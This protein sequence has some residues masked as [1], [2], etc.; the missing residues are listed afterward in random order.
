MAHGNA[1]HSEVGALVNTKFG[2]SDAVLRVEG[3]PSARTRS[4]SGYAGPYNRILAERVG[5]LLTS[6]GLACLL[7]RTRPP[8]PSILLRFSLAVCGGNPP[9]AISRGSAELLQQHLDK[10]SQTG[11]PEG[12]ISNTT[13]PPMLGRLARGPYTPSSGRGVAMI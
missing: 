10:V 8:R 6:T 11:N 12:L 13:G 5:D 2:G 9:A 4:R 1:R 3:S 7:P